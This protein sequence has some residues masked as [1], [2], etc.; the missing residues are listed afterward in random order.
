MNKSVSWLAAVLM[1]AACSNYSVPTP[2]KFA[3]E[4]VTV[5]GKR[6]ELNIAGWQITDMQRSWT[7]G[8]SIRISVAGSQKRAQTYTFHIAS[9]TLHSADVECAFEAHERRVTNSTGFDFVLGAKAALAC[10]INGKQDRWH[11]ELGDDSDS[12]LGGVL[13]GPRQYRVRGVGTAAFM[14]G[15]GGPVGGFHIYAGDNPVAVVQVLTPRRLL[16]VP[17]LD[18]IDRAALIPAAAA[19]MLMDESVKDF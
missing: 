1:L 11:L 7:K 10:D 2:D 4:E 18:P 5:T 14:K 9:D 13:K 16:F 17:G 19:L 3:G 8:S 12:P 6:K 15:R